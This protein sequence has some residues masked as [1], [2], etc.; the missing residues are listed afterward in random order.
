[1]N[2]AITNSFITNS[3]ITNYM[4]TNVFGRKN[5][6]D[7]DTL[8]YNPLLDMISVSINVCKNESQFIQKKI[9]FDTF[10]SRFNSCIRLAKLAIAKIEFYADKG[11]LDW[12]GTLDLD[13]IEETLKEMNL[14]IQRS[15]NIIL[16][17]EK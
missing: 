10:V 11:Y 17:Y 4:S 2:P 6:I 9:D 3:M 12:C 1:M 14:D 16:E 7:F 15:K 8:D 13:R 5:R